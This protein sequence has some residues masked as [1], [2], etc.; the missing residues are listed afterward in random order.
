MLRAWRQLFT[1]EGV[2]VGH[3]ILTTIG[4]SAIVSNEQ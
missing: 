1:T 2:E 4:L 3:I